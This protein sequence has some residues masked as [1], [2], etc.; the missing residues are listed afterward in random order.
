MHLAGNYA[1]CPGV[2]LIVREVIEPAIHAVAT[3][4]QIKVSSGIRV[5]EGASR[6]GH[7][8]VDGEAEAP[9]TSEKG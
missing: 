3:S 5:P 7:I 1:G 9:G 6:V 2:P 8:R 4:V